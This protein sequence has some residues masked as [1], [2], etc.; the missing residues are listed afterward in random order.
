MPFF[1][2]HMHGLYT[3]RGLVTRAC[4]AVGI[5]VLLCAWF[6][7]LPVLTGTAVLMLSHPSRFYPQPVLAAEDIV[8]V[9]LLGFT[10]VQFFYRC[11]TVGLFGMQNPIRLAVERV[12]VRCCCCC[13]CWCSN[14]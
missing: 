12:W 11:L 4:R 9:W 3:I 2:R 7:V 13:C 8:Y 10:A 6:F 5:V 14:R 1:I